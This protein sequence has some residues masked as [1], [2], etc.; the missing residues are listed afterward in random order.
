MYKRVFLFLLT[1]TCL[2]SSKS[3]AQVDSVTVDKVSIINAKHKV[4]GIY[5]TF[6]EFR[7]NQ[8]FY[9]DSFEIIPSPVS[10]NANE[11]DW[12]GNKIEYYLDKVEYSGIKKRT[13]KRQFGLSFS[14]NFFGY[15]FN[16]T[17]YIAFWRFHPI[18]EFG[19]LS[20]IRVN[21]DRF[22]QNSGGWSGGGMGNTATFG[23]V[24]GMVRHVSK[25]FVLDYMTGELISI[26]TFFLKD[27]FKLWD[28]ELYQEYKKTKHKN[29]LE[30]QLKFVRK[31][32]ERN[33]IRF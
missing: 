28:K 7:R 12:F 4:E 20:L 31:F 23:G 13:V 8:P 2:G 6:D 14:S 29:N 25:Y 26:N 24:G 17:V 30:I 11:I 18:V 16:D 21:E 1:I 5:K 3:F 22:H 27:K 33:P 9:T 32:N 19:H 10:L 15:C